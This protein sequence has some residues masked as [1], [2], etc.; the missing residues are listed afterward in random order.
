[1]RTGFLSGVAVSLLIVLGFVSQ[2]E[3]RR[4]KLAVPSFGVTTAFTT[5]QKK[6][7]YREEGLEVEQ[8]L[9]RAPI[10]TQ[11][12]LSGEADFST[13]GAGG[14]LAALR[15]G[16]LRFILHTYYRPMFWLYAKPDIREIKGLKGKKF[17]ISGPGGGP[18][19]L[20]AEVFRRHGLEVGRDVTYISIGGQSTRFAA[21]Q[22]GAVDA[23]YFGVPFIFTAQDAGFRELI[24]LVNQDL[25]ELQGSIV[26]RERLLESDPG[27]VE[28]FVRGTLKGFRYA[29]DRRSGTIP[30]MA[31]I[32]KIGEEL[33]GKNYDAIRPAM[34]GDGT[35]TEEVQKKAIESIL[36]L[37]GIK[38]LPPL[39]RIF[40]YSHVRSVR[41]ELDRAG[42]EPG[43]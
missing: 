35:V 38:E 9:M 6:G 17:G 15:G 39:E 21:L 1:M 31:G 32:L 22:T 34:T 19:I 29:R 40:S 10:A 14:L 33:A 36:K 4:V 3:A 16:P 2:G 20:F 28:K 30:I 5:A 24:A 25:V 41:A 26:V 43:P 7:Y 23:T 12:L 13:V 8:V 42:W 11:A 37:G 27:Q 18:D